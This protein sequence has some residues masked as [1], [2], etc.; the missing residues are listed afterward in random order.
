MIFWINSVA[1]AEICA[2]ADFTDA[3]NNFGEAGYQGRHVVIGSKTFMK[4]LSVQKGLSRAAAAYYKWSSGAV[5]QLGNL[6][7]RTDCIIVDHSS[8]APLLRAQQWNVPLRIF[9]NPDLLGKSEILCENLT[10]CDALVALCNIAV[11]KQAPSC[12]ISFKPVAG[13]GIPHIRI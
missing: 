4:E 5:T 8:I 3:L 12:T 7:K 2:H 1:N 9:S 13:E 11:K 10:D 6:A